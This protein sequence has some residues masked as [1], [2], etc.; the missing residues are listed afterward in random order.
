M[1]PDVLNIIDYEKTYIFYNYVYFNY[2]IVYFEEGLNKLID[3]TFTA[4]HM[5]YATFKF[6]YYNF[7]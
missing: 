4:S 5:L 2:K 7:L 1:N 3:Y 6:F